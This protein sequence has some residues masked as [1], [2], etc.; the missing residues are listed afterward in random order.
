MPLEMD[1]VH[2]DSSMER[3]DL[4]VEMW[5]QGSRFAYQIPAGKE[6]RRVVVDPRQVLP[7]VDR[8]NNVKAR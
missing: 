6:V 2:P 7:D 3:I 4:P 8:S 5:N 1:L